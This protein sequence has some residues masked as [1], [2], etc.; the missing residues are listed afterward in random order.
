ME[1]Q[2]NKNQ[3]N[4]RLSLSVITSPG[5]SI[6]V[7]NVPD[8]SDAIVP[9]N[10][11]SEGKLTNNQMPSYRP[12]KKIGPNEK[13]SISGQKSGQSTS[14]TGA[15]RSKQPKKVMVRCKAVKARRKKCDGNSKSM[16]HKIIRIDENSIKVFSIP[17]I[18]C[19]DVGV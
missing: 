2:K 7:E 13:G 4:N 10:T 1:E 8:Y 3:E 18:L 6:T 15:P 14:R 5:N 19:K 12:S 9:V 11:T 16:N 17:K